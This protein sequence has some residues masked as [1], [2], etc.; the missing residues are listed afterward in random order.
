MVVP[1]LIRSP[2]PGLLRGWLAATARPEIGGRGWRLPGGGRVVLAHRRSHPSGAFRLVAVDDLC[3]LR[4]PEYLD[5][6]GL[7]ARVVSAT[8]PEEPG[9][10]WVA[11]RFGLEGGERPPDRVVVPATLEEIPGGE[12]VRQAL[13]RLPE[14]RRSY[15]LG[16]WRAEPKEPAPRKEASILHLPAPAGRGDDP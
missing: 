9:R 14:P 13:E 1:E 3:R 16:G 15:A 6:L 11:A 8:S 5:L 10:E 7:G 12:A 4:E 2:L